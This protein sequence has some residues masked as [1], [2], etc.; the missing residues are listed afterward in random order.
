MK[1][2]W[3]INPEKCGREFKKYLSDDEWNE[4]SETFTG[5][6]SE[7]NWE[8]LFNLLDFYRK[9]PIEVSINLG[10]EY[11]KQTDKEVT[12]YMRRMRE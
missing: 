4:L 5:F 9:I 3:K 11:P 7:D 10:Y 1:N 8:C 6:E 12:K 2:N